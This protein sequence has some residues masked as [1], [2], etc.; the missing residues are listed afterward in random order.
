MELRID[1]FVAGAI[2][3]MTCESGNL[4]GH[5]RLPATT[6]IVLAPAAQAR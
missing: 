4:N 2:P 6:N 3:T 5:S 1:D